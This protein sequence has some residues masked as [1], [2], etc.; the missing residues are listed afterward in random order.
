MLSS[1]WSKL[2]RKGQI[3]PPNA[4]QKS[5]KLIYEQQK[6]AR[7]AVKSAIRQAQ[8]RTTTQEGQEEGH[9]HHKHR[10]HEEESVIID[11]IDL[12]QTPLAK[13]LAPTSTKYS[14][15]FPIVS[16]D[17][18]FVG[19]GVEGREHMLARCSIVDYYGRSIYDKYIIPTE[20]ITQY[21]TE[22]HGI[23]AAHLSPATNPNLTAFKQCQQDVSEILNGK[24]LVGHAIHHDLSVLLLSHPK[25][26]TR[27]TTRYRTL[28]PR[29]HPK[30]L[31]EITSEHL[32][33]EIQS[34]SH[35]SIEDARAAM[36]LYR[37][38]RDEWEHHL[39]HPKKPVQSTKKEPKPRKHGKRKE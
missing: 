33:I 27:D 34:T 15:D 7:N 30:K 22:I 29:R 28:N 26:S 3:D 13:L 21:R 18:E 17:C 31:S 4:K 20:K 8:L 19:V 2:K 9:H 38:Y 16:M 5:A 14:I 10:H 36:A 11:Q 6:A 25:P 24:I 32:Q 12:S 1:N 39:K 37:K 35:D 23:T